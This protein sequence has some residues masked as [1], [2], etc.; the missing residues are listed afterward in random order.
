M[1]DTLGFITTPTAAG[2][3]WLLAPFVDPAVKASSASFIASLAAAMGQKVAALRKWLRNTSNVETLLTAHVSAL[4]AAYAA[5]HTDL[6]IT[7]MCLYSGP[8]P[9]FAK[10]Q[11]QIHGKFG[12]WSVHDSNN[13]IAWLGTGDAAL[14][15]KKRR[16]A[17]LKH[18]GSLLDEVGTLALPHHG[19][20]HNFHP[21]LLDRIK[22][23][24]C[25]AAADQ[26]ST[27]RHPGTAVA[28][29]V[30]STG[31]FL[32]VVTANIDSEVTEQVL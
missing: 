32:S 16:N 15:D 26:F 20:D 2:R 27:W 19:S 30:A 17:F 21:A 23:S 24:F 8:A 3:A 31:R 9:V 28:Q 29:S 7:S 13:S 5:I 25:V 12:K 4:K 22:P 18:Y 14:A 10:L 11:N 6:N 1:P